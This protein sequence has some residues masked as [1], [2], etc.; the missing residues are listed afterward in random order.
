VGQPRSAKV[1]KTLIS[2]PLLP[3]AFPLRP[4]VRAVIGS[5]ADLGAAARGPDS[6]ASAFL[7]P[8]NNRIMEE[9]R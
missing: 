7:V 1:H 3:F 4:P 9:R 5:E 8:T 6:Q 2:D